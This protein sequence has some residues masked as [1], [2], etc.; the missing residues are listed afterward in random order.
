MTNQYLGSGFDDFLEEEDI[1][2]ECTAE[3]MK[4]VI[5]WEIQQALAET[6]LTKAR[7]AIEMHS[8]RSQVD[9]LLDPANTSLSLKTLAAAAQIIGKQ[10]NISFTDIPTAKEGEEIRKT[11]KQQTSRA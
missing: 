11:Y 3:A 8:S 9:R 4:R 5:A 10:V 6:Q 1:L 7:F 2:E